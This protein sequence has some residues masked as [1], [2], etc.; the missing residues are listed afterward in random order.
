MNRRNLITTAAF[1]LGLLGA[2]TAF[3]VRPPPKTAVTTEWYGC[4]FADDV[5]ESQADTDDE[6]TLGWCYTT[7]FS[8]G[9]TESACYSD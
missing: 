5:C 2:S 8:D 1:A 9:S 4:I 3:A 7:T 6:D